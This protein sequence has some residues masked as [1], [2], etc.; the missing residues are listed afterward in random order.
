MPT[1]SYIVFYELCGIKIPDFTSDVWFVLLVDVAVVGIKV[2]LL[3]ISL[4]REGSEVWAEFSL[5]VVWVVWA[6]SLAKIFVSDLDVAE[7]CEIVVV[8]TIIVVVMFVVAGIDFGLLMVKMSTSAGKVIKLFM[9]VDLV[10]VVFLVDD[11][12]GLVVTEVLL[13]SICVLVVSLVCFF[14]G[15]V[16]VTPLVDSDMETTVVCPVFFEVEIFPAVD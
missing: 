12:V 9:I 6:E 7:A 10:V 2:F 1:T 15:V 16:A 4:V 13:V 14:F 11:D 5:P 3:V 8:V